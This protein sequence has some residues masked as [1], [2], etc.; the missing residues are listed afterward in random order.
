MSLVACIVR[1]PGLNDR[2]LR[3]IC[4]LSCLCW[5]GVSLGSLQTWNPSVDSWQPLL[6]LYDTVSLDFAL[7]HFERSS[8]PHPILSPQGRRFSLSFLSYPGPRMVCK[9]G[10]PINFRCARGAWFAKCPIVGWSAPRPVSCWEQDGSRSV[11]GSAVRHLGVNLQRKS[12]KLG[13]HTPKNGDLID[14]ELD[15]ADWKSTWF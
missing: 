10:E 12:S 2:E 6:C 9:H 1:K 13:L 14:L 11:R 15:L 8:W 4:L 5:F 7:R 3:Y